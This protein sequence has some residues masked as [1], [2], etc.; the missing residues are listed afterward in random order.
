VIVVLL[1]SVSVACFHISVAGFALAAGYTSQV[2]CGE[3]YE[4]STNDTLF[5]LATSLLGVF[6]C[7]RA[8]MLINHGWLSYTKRRRDIARGQSRSTFSIWMLSALNLWTIVKVTALLLV[9]TAF[10]LQAGGDLTGF[11]NL[12][13]TACLVNCLQFYSFAEYWKPFKLLVKTLN[14]AS[15]ILGNFL[16]AMSVT[17]VFFAFAGHSKL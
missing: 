1:V 14:E 5:A 13:G 6:W 9:P 4:S 3:M 17:F 2:E 10:I 15:G 16:I 12:M 11:Q 8:A 7:L